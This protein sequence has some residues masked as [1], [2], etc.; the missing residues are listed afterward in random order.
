MTILKKIL[1]TIQNNSQTNTVSAEELEL[2][3]TP[4]LKK[5]TRLK[6]DTCD[7]PPDNSQF[8]SHFGGQPYFEIG[9]SWPVSKS[10]RPM[11]LVFQ[12][13]NEEGIALPD[14]I[15]LVQLYYD[16]ESGAKTTFDDGWYVKIYGGLDMERTINLPRP[17]GLSEGTYCEIVFENIISLPDWE[18]IDSYSPEAVNISAALNQEDQWEHYEKVVDKL[19][20]SQACACQLGGYPKWLLEDETPLKDLGNVKLLFQISCEDKMGIMW[21]ASAVFYVFYDAE[22]KNTEFVLQYR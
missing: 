5:A 4:L 21:G 8:Q 19:C 1:R 6:V 13:F 20:G 15:K 14:T 11:Q 18:G 2:V 3:V 10:G 22:T 12:V 9:E 17:E 16:F 7:T